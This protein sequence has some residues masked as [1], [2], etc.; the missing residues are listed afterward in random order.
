MRIEAVHTCSELLKL[1]IQSTIVRRSETV[2]K[3]VSDVL[4]KLLIVGITDTGENR[5]N[6]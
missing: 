6:I 5:G 2:T 4:A 1:A 3:T